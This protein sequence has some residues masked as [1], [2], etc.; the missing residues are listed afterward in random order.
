MAKWIIRENSDLP[1]VSIAL[2]DIDGVVVPRKY[3]TTGRIQT[4]PNARVDHHFYWL[5]KYNNNP[6]S[7]PI[8][9]TSGRS[10]KA[11]KGIAERMENKNVIIHEH[12]MGWYDQETKSNKS[13]FDDQPELSHMKDSVKKIKSLG[14]YLEDKFDKIKEELHNIGYE[15]VEKI[16]MAPG[17]NFSVAIDL[18]YNGKYEKSLRVNGNDF[19]KSVWRYV[20]EEYK[21][22][23]FTNQYEIQDFVESK[24]RKI[25][26]F[27]D[28]SAVNFRP[29]VSKPMS[30]KFL[31]KEGGILERKY[32]VEGREVGL[33]DDRD[34]DSMRSMKGSVWTVADASV[35]VRNEVVRRY[36]EDKMGYISKLRNIGGLRDILKAMNRERIYLKL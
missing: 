1:K 18:P 21:K 22:E 17:K 9:L 15:K 2:T 11:I 26:T 13:I 36:H 33:I 7:I 32:K 20:P 25:S 16:V 35:D 29:P 27:V 5:R 31:L 34:I 8:V 3:D 14:N 28:S 6:K 4:G 23:I 10:L 24:E 19:F 12:G 30:L